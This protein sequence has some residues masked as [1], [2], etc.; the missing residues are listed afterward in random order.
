MSVSQLFLPVILHVQSVIE[1]TL[2]RIQ[3]MADAMCIVDKS[4]N[5]LRFRN[6]TEDQARIMGL[7]FEHVSHRGMHTVRDFDPDVSSPARTQQSS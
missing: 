2:Q 4:G 3:D 6:M 7:A 1:E 5:V